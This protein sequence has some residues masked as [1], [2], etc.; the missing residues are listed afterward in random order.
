MCVRFALGS[1]LAAFTCLFDVLI[2]CIK[3]KHELPGPSLLAL[4][5]LRGLNTANKLWAPLPKHAPVSATPLPCSSK[6]TVLRHDQKDEFASKVPPPAFTSPRK[7]QK[8]QPKQLKVSTH[9]PLISLHLPAFI[10]AH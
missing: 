9:L 3:C 8:T 5:A 1:G 4:G 10:S 2:S 7:K 6:S